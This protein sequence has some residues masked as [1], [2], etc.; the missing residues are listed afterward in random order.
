MKKQSFAIHFWKPI[1]IFWLIAAAVFG[2]FAA[3]LPAKLEGDGFRTDGDYE[4]VQQALHDTFHFPEQTLLV[5]FEKRNH[6]SSKTFQT[7]ISSVLDE[8]DQTVS[9]SAIDSPLENKEWLKEDIAY[10]A[11]HFDDPSKPMDPVIDDVRAI[12][13]KEDGISLTGGP[14]ISKDINQASQDDLKRAELIGLPVALIVLLLALGAVVASILPLV[15]GGMTIIVGF[16]ILSFIADSVD[17]AI[18]IL[19]IAPML[20]LALSIDFSLLFINRYKEERSRGRSIDEAIGITQAKAGHS[21]LFSALCVFIGLGSVLLIDIDIFK[22]VAIGGMTVIAVAVVASMTLLPALLKLLGSRIY[23]GRI[24]RISGNSASR[25][26]LFARFVMKRPILVALLA[27]FLLGT[28]VIPGKNMHL[29]IP[30]ADSLPTTFES[31]T[32]YDKIEEN[33]MKDTASTVYA[34]AERKNGWL[35]EDGLTVMK[36]LE[37]KLKQSETVSGV[38]T[39]F[40]I[41]GQRDPA[42]LAASLENPQTAA[43]LEPAIEGFIQGD[44]LLLPISLNAEAASDE[45]QTV[46]RN[47]S[48][49]DWP[50]KITFGGQ[51]KFNQELYDEIFDKAVPVL[52]VILISTFFILMIAFR[53]VLIPLKAIIMNVLSLAAT[54]GILVWLF[55][56]GHL[57][58]EPASVSLILPVLVFSLVFGLSMDYEVFLISRIREFYMDTY[59]NAYATVEGLASTSKIITSAAAIMIAIT[60]AFAF[61]GVVPVK[62]IGIGIAMAIA[63]DATIV[64]LLLVPSLMKLLGAANWWMPFQKKP[65]KQSS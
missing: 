55:Q 18:F 53:S 3:K 2:F 23:K 12:L 63:I 37:Q 6:E 54:F 17:L 36:E 61:T 62:Q 32:A 60:G 46:V 58:M 43:K 56:G 26:R 33:F 5:L 47:W 52:A 49:D 21:I 48:E 42:I 10:A 30:A 35:D 64:R 31:R 11:I 50:V 9:P 16:G 8:I 65:K 39:L 38:E 13:A 22:N 41:S 51:P 34:V 24:L 40:S 20:G 28:A 25:W 1:L 27:L 45:A 57:G 29:A 7:N 19:N 15:I 4:V 59:D 44:K 14:V